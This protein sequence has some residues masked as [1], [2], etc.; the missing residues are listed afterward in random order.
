MPTSSNGIE[1]GTDP[2][3]WR[4]DGYGIQLVVGLKG[5]RWQRFGVWATTT[6]VQR[7]ECN[8]IIPLQ[9]ETGGC[10]Y[11]ASLGPRLL[12]NIWIRYCCYS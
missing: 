6:F 9:N 10:M 8:T 3:V 11:L 12:P 5:W 4:S 2:G 7:K 1:G